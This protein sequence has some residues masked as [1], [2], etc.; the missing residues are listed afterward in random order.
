M[1][2]R[3]EVPNK[4]PSHHASAFKEQRDRLCRSLADQGS[5]LEACRARNSHFKSDL[6]PSSD[7]PWDVSSHKHPLR[8]RAQSCHSYEHADCLARRLSTSEVQSRQKQ[9]RCRTEAEPAGTL[10]V[11]RVSNER[12]SFV[13]SNASVATSKRLG[14]PARRGAIACCSDGREARIASP[15]TMSRYLLESSS[16]W[17]PTRRRRRFPP[18]GPSQLL[19]R[20]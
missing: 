1:F 5:R 2:V 16:K 19:A 14:S 10:Y 7:R 20:N 17:S 4:G 18:L 6:E 12:V 3:S 11:M 9:V 8:V 15:A 13:L